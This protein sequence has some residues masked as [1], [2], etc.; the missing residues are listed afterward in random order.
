MFREKYRCW[1]SGFKTCH[2]WWFQERLWKISIW[3]SGSTFM[4]QRIDYL[5]VE[6]C[7]VR[8]WGQP[9]WNSDISRKEFNVWTKAGCSHGRTY[10]VDFCSRVCE[11][12]QNQVC[13]P[14][15]GPGVDVCGIGTRCLKQIN[16]EYRCQENKQ[17]DKLLQTKDL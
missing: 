6:T 1:T 8:F 17:V 7:A 5:I 11:I 14:I 15:T 9:G 10:D 16:G 2:S 13:S 12:G 3:S 4:V